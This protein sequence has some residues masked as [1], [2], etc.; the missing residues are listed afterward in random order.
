[1]LVCLN[2]L[3]RNPNRWTDWDE[4]WHKGG[5]QGCEGTWG[6]ISTCNP[7]RK[8]VCVRKSYL[9]RSDTLYPDPGVPGGQ[10]RGL[11]GFWSLSCAFWW[12]LYKT[13]VAVHHQLS[14]GRLPLRTP[15]LDLQG[16]GPSVLL[17]PWFFTFKESFKI[18]FVVSVLN[19]YF[20]SCVYDLRDRALAWRSP[21]GP[22]GSMSGSPHMLEL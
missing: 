7:P 22:G 18:K 14:E 19:R 1:M 6:G 12:I 21:K 8:W 16:P 4:I 3:Y 10:K 5:T 17:K 20:L 2:V 13:K 11:V 9:V 15:N